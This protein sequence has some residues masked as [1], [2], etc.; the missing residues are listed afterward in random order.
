LSTTSTCSGTPR[1]LIRFGRTQGIKTR[2]SK[3]AFSASGLQIA[4]SDANQF[5]GPGENTAEFSGVADADLGAPRRQLRSASTSTTSP[6]LSRR[7]PSAGC[8]CAERPGANEAER[9]TRGGRQGKA[10]DEAERL[11]MRSRVRRRKR[12]SWRIEFVRRHQV[13][14]P[15]AGQR[16]VSTRPRCCSSTGA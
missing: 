10:H 13:G 16:P 3:R 7:S 1:S 12:C 4:S 11:A 15:L 8:C 14:T 2:K 5:V 6:L 9:G